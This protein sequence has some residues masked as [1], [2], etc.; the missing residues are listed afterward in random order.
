MSAQGWTNAQGWTPALKRG[1]IPLHPLTFG[2][3]LGKPFATLRHNPKVLFGFAIVVQLVV[4]VV[5]A[6]VVVAVVF[7]TFL[8]METLSPSSP[9]FFPVMWGAIAIN[10][11]VV[12]AMSFVSLAFTAI[13]QGV[14]AADVGHAALGEKPALGKLWRLMRPAFW[15]L[16]GWSV[17]Q[18]LA[19]LVLMAVIGGIV[20][21]GVMA[22]VGGSAEGVG[23][24]VVIGVLLVLA[25][26]PLWVWLS[27]KLL[28][29][30]SILVLERAGIRAALVRSWRL[31]RG[32]FWTAFG[33]VFLVNLIMGTAV[34]VVSMPL[35]LLGSLFGTV[36]APTGPNDTSGIALYLITALAPQLLIYVL[37]A[38]TVVVQCAAGVFIYL[39]C[40]MRYE[41]LDHSLISYLERRDLGASEEELGDPFA[42]D[43]A[44][45]V[46]S[47][48]PPKPM[49]SYATAP[50]GWGQYPAQ[51]P[52]PGQQPYPAAPQAYPAQPPYPAQQQ[53]HPPQAPYL[54][55][56]PPA[57]QPPAPQRP[58]QPPASA[59]P[60]PP[61]S[62]SPWAPPGSGSA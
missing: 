44:R 20:A 62:E 40:R 27:T 16:L 61:E 32:R 8:R 7:A 25:M 19:A 42:V 34:S 50:V 15:R 58:Q 37:Q 28:L 43:P 2:A 48:P 56:Q 23:L 49:P 38:I 45:A 29:V 33:V 17:L 30:P 53:A 36:I 13:M 10:A 12:L 46:N 9:D 6:L 39:D 4:A 60:T 5:T 22:G 18:A 55:P 14:V 31:T 21:L 26:I 54:A 24:T 47:T 57:P 41:G 52:Y 35:S 59:Q 51:P 11:L 1:L 3:L